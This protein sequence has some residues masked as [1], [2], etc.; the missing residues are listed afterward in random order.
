MKKRLYRVKTGK[1]LAGVCGG[2]A[3]YIGLDP[4]IVRILWALVAWFA[5]VGIVLYIICAIVV[6]EKE[7][8]I[9]DI[10]ED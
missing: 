8:D 9:I 6:P 1:M 2:L 5:G 7:D 4:T 3:E 10:D